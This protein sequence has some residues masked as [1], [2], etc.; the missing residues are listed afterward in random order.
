MTKARRPTG[1]RDQNRQ[2]RDAARIVGLDEK[3]TYRF[4]EDVEI[5]SRRYGAD[6]DFQALIEV[7]REIKNEA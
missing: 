5:E 1:N 2:I 7:A 3:Q 4:A 6:L